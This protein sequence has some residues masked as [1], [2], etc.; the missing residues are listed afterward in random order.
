MSAETQETKFESLKVKP[1]AR[2]KID[3]VQ[4]AIQRE[5][6]QHAEAPSISETILI[7]ADRFLETA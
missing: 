7:M 3:E 2:A 4:A 6:G 5:R 1:A